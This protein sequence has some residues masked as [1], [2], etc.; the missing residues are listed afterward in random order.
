MKKIFLLLPFLFFYSKFY[1]QNSVPSAAATSAYIDD[2]SSI[3]SGEPNINFPVVKLPTLN[4]NI[5]LEFSLDYKVNNHANGSYKND[6]IGDYWKLFGGGVISRETPYMYFDGWSDDTSSCYAAS[7]YRDIYFYSFLGKSGKFKF[8]KS[9]TTNAFQL[10]NLSPNNLKFEY[11]TTGDGSKIN[12]IS[13]FIITDDDGIRYTFSDYSTSVLVTD[14]G[15]PNEKRKEYK[16]AFYLSKVTDALNNELLNF[17]YQKNIHNEPYTTK[18]KYTSCELQ[19]AYSPSYGTVSLNYAYSPNQGAP[20]EPY[21]Y[22]L[23]KFTLTD[24]ENHVI[25]SSNLVYDSEYLKALE[26]T[27]KNSQ[28][29]EKTSFE[30]GLTT[31]PS[32]FPAGAIPGWTDPNSNF[33]LKKVILPTGGVIKYT[34]QANQYFRDKSG[35]D[36]GLNYALYSGSEGNIG[37]P[38]VQFYKY[39]NLSFNS[40]QNPS[41]TAQLKYP[42]NIVTSD[43]KPTMV[44][45]PEFY[46]N[47][48]QGYLFDPPYPGIWGMKEFTTLSYDSKFLGQKPKFEFRILNSNNALVYE[49]QTGSKYYSLAPGQYTLEI[50]LP[51]QLE[52]T[53]DND[54]NNIPSQADNKFLL[55]GGKGGATLRYIDRIL[56]PYKNAVSTNNSGVR[57]KNIEFYENNNTSTPIKSLNYEY[58]EFNNSMNSSGKEFKREDYGIYNYNND[59]RIPPHILYKNVKISENNKGHIKYY[60]KTTADNLKYFEDETGTII[61]LNNFNSY[62]NDSNYPMYDLIKEGIL[63]KKEIYDS[64]NKLLESIECDY[65]FASL[66]AGDV[67]RKYKV[68]GDITAE[69][70]II[71]QK[72]IITKTYDTATSAFINKISES[73]NSTVNLAPTLMKETFSDGT[74]VETSYQYAKDKNIVHLLAANMIATPLETQVKNN[75]E[76]VSKTEIKYDNP[77][78]LFPTSMLSLDLQSNN[79]STEVT[80]EKYDSKGNIV[81]YTTKE[82]ISTTIIWG[83]HQTLPIAKIEGAKLSDI[84]QSMIDS[85]VN[86]SNADATAAANNDETSFLAVLDSFRKNNSNYIVTTYTYDPLIGIRTT[87]PPSGIREIRMYDSAGRPEKVLDINGKVL[88]QLKYNYKH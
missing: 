51:Q 73:T 18:L 22:K 4:K 19:K 49:A 7:C 86:S 43:G 34:F 85:I 10:I 3:A 50:I 33:L 6:I 14:K 38:E 72:K 39:I 61:N 79:M 84:Q 48:F 66:P 30:Y 37:D 1:T 53:I 24:T 11:L 12:N 65:V 9:A 63:D 60:F 42:F 44:K 32:Y 40:Q 78:N 25:S 82:G 67:S 69:P 76:L 83:Y 52:Y 41:S 36:Y 20:N 2:P 47:E 21:E 35:S 26:K 13:S 87:T 46:I 62:P 45:I 27:D 75:G 88:N 57:V 29:I 64:D 70:S 15:T 74:N 58:T 77:A 8:T 68:V 59:S 55:K 54:N 17:T 56:P 71:K 31:E 23:L 5:G 28:I 16:S 81:Q 80:F